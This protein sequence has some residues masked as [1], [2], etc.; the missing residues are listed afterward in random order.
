MVGPAPA[1][2]FEPAVR[3]A[4]AADREELVRLAHQAL[5]HLDTQRGGAEFRDR[6]ARPRPAHDTI[7][8]DLAAAA[9]HG[10]TIVL[11]GTLGTVAVG[12]AV[13]RIE[14][15]RNLPLAVVSDVY[16]EPPAR[17][18]GVGR[19]LMSELVA[20][21]EADGCGGIQA[22]ALPGDRATKNFFEGFGL[23][24]RKITVHRELGERDEL[25]DG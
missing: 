15:T 4:T 17:G 6:E 12:Y 3:T 20:R 19:A 10:S 22:E 14:A 16:V 9:E 13:A 5:D 8:A 2:S 7:E 11:V 21:A 25:P 1:S 24:A 23:V 18:V